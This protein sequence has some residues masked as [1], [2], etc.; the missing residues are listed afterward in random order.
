MKNKSRR[1]RK[2]SRVSALSKIILILALSWLAL[3]YGKSITDR[4]V[5]DSKSAA[6]VKQ[7]VQYNF[8]RDIAPLAQKTQ[9]E[10]NIL[11]SVTIAQACLESN[12]GQSTLASKYHNLF[13]V[14][15]SGDVPTVTLDTQEYENDQWVTIQ[16]QFRVYESYQA[17]VEAHSKLFVEGTTWNPNQYAS[18]LTAP[19]HTSAAK[20]IQ[21]SGYATDPTYA[22][23]LIEMIETY[24]LENYDKVNPSA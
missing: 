1:R 14:K 4:T 22:D 19:D 18:V 7:M 13:G 5:S 11:A 12:F 2:P 3:T 21:T 17:A 15:A 23:K 10:Y 16:G 24:Q 20:A 6:E 9:Q 8:I